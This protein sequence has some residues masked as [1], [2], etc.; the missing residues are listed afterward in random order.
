MMDT[1]DLGGVYKCGWDY[2]SKFFSLRNVLK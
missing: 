2:F 1:V